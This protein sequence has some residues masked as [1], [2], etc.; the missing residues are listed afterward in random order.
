MEFSG[1]NIP[2][3]SFILLINVKMPTIVAILAF[4]NRINFMLSRVEHEECFITLRLCFLAT[5]LNEVV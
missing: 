2:S 3:Q 5:R 4:M 1:L